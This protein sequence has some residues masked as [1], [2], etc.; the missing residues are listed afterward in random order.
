ML[1]CVFLSK[2]TLDKNSGNDIWMTILA[3]RLSDRSGT[4]CN[5]LWNWSPVGWWIRRKTK[6]YVT[7]PF[8]P[9]RLLQMF[10]LL[11]WNHHRY[12]ASTKEESKSY[13]GIEIW[14]ACD[15]KQ[16]YRCVGESWDG[17]G[18]LLPYVL[19]KATHYWIECKGEEEDMHNLF[20]GMSDLQGAYLQRML[21]RGVR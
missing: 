17:I 14:D 12:C 1:W 18:E 2:V 9:L 6:L 19:Q 7:R 3:V 4:V 11:E 10:F 5:E 13:C 21:E 8:C 15:I 16:M 20:Y